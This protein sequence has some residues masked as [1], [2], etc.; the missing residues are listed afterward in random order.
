MVGDHVFTKLFHIPD[1]VP[2]TDIGDM[3]IKMDY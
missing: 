1:D 3:F 2:E